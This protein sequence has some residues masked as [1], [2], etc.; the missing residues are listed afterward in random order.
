MRVSFCYKCQGMTGNSIFFFPQ[1]V[2]HVIQFSTLQ[3]AAYIRRISCMGR[4]RPRSKSLP[5]YMLFLTETVPL[6]YTFRRDRDPFLVPSK[7]MAPLSHK[8]LLRVWGNFERSCTC[9]SHINVIIDHKC[10]HA[11]K[12]NKKIDHFCKR[13]SNYVQKWQ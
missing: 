4:L 8:S 3:L 2:S 6:S 10:N 13:R 1:R 5:F 11:L 7:K 9:R 12:C